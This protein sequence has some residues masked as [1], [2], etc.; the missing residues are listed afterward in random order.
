[1]ALGAKAPEK[2]AYLPGLKPIG[3]KLRDEKDLY[4]RDIVTKQYPI[5]EVYNEI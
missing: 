3:I 2:T 1:M 4:N 5:T